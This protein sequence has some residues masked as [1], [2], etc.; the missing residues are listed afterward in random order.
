[1]LP[2]SSFTSL[3]ITTYN[4][5]QLLEIVLKSVM[6]QTRMPLEVII[7]DDGS[8]EETRLLI[9]QYKEI[10][11]VPLRHSWIEDKGFRAARS[12]NMAIKKAKG[13]YI[14]ILDGDILI[15][16]HFIEDHELLMKK[17]QFVA[18]SRAY[19][20]QKQT[21]LRKQTKNTHIH[22]FSAGLKRRFILLRLP[23]AHNWLKGHSGLSRARSCNLAFWKS[24]F[25]KVN[26]FEEAFEGWGYEDHEFV[27]R[28]YNIGIQR[29][30]TK[31]L[32]SAIHLYHQV[33]KEN[34]LY[35]KNREILQRTIQEKRTRAERGVEND[36]KTSYE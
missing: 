1:M 34:R 5:P 11:P 8:G 23:F 31:L 33:R 10:F 12:R 3:V 25:L 13:E 4:S 19:L 7:A 24:D 15:C 29:K 22:F 16:P 32:A 35:Q 30:N 27:Q 17:G 9:E 6:R 28:L 21:E 26:G 2:V 18:G 14:I 20:S 36:E